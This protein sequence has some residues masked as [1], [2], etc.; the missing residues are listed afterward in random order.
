MTPGAVRGE[1]LEA[2]TEQLGRV[3]RGVVDVVAR[4][5][6]G[7]PTVVRTAPRLDDG[8]PFP[9]SYYLTCPAAVKGAS[10]LEAQHVMA[11][12]N[13]RLAEDLDL[14]A[15]YRLAHED[16]LRRRAELGDVPEIAGVS[17]G[18]M[19]TR[20]KCL[21]AL[22]AHT[23]A[24]GPGVNPIGDETLRLLEGAGL[25]SPTRCTC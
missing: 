19:P 6:C 20:V 21:H 5:V 1:D 3:P 11:E 24:V 9:T 10:T 7:R 4:C 2:L 18:G 22:L 13:T 14:A 17:A 16:Y 12:M 23:L 8:T 25:W 15:A